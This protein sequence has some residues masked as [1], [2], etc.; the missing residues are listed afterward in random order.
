MVAVMP[1]SRAFKVLQE[2]EQRLSAIWFEII[3]DEYTAQRNP[4]APATLGPFLPLIPTAVATL[5]CT[6][7]MV[8]AATERSPPQVLCSPQTVPCTARL[9]RVAMRIVEPSSA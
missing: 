3:T 7:L 1:S 6:I 5:S 9:G 8:S 2:M 4:E